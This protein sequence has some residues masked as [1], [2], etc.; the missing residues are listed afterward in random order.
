M[1]DNRSPLS[2]SPIV[3][4]ATAFSASDSVNTV[5]PATLARR[6]TMPASSVARPPA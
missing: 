2:L 6:T 5:T 4:R 1:P 3:F